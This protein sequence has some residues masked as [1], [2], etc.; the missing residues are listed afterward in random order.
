[1]EILGCCVNSTVN[2]MSSRSR[3]S[4]NDSNI[5]CYICGEYVA[6]SQRQNITNFVKNVY[7]AYF[8]IKLGDQDKTWAP[9]KVCR[10]CVESLRRWS[11][12]KQ[13]S[14]SFGVPMVW[15]EPKGHGND[16]YFC[17]C[18]V[19][20][21]N[22]KN[23]HNI[24]YP[25]LPSAICPIL[26]QANVSVPTPAP[27]LID[28]EDST[29]SSD[30]SSSECQSEYKCFE[31]EKPRL[32]SQE[33]LNDLVRDLDLP[34]VSAVL[35][36]SRLKSR[37]M[38]DSEVTFSWY[39]HREKEYLPFFTKED[40]LVYCVDIKGLIEKLGTTYEPSDWRLFI[41]SSKR[42]LKAVLLHNGNTFASIPLAHSIHMKES[43][44]NMEILLTKLKYHDHAWKVCVDIK[45]LNMLQGQQSGYIKFRCLFCEWDSRDKKNHW[46]KR[47]WPTRV[48]RTLGQ[49]NI[50]NPA[51]VESS[52]VILPP[53]HIKLGL[54]KQVVK[55]LDKQGL[56]LKYISEKFPHLSA[57]KVREGVF[58]GPQI[59]MLI[60]D[61]LFITKMN[62]T[63]KNAWQSFKDV[64]SNFLGNKKSPNY[65]TIVEQMLTNFQTLG[66]RMSGKSPLFAFH[67]DFFLQI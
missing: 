51:L 62:D 19:S 34:K 27:V 25:N 61:E 31:G 36:G 50:T 46:V 54:M 2:T 66:C 39:K 41:D 6:K 48:S 65:Q 23:K 42:S 9:H 44:E 64:V 63:E 59:R 26:H 22:T 11:K 5:F 60:N 17:S 24:Q 7:Y 37:N 16:C 55:A 32:F 57:E 15:R 30:L 28:V 1:M 53:L 4:T 43:Y 67:F 20:G 8:G 52:K 33:E 3:G 35:L 58:I 45:V 47:K 49:K 18:N 10:I 12:G 14:M 29:T 38:L 40:D 21:F 56:C 13:K